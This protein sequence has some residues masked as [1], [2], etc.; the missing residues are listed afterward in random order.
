[1]PRPGTPRIA[2]SL[3]KHQFLNSIYPRPPWQSVTVTTT[4]SSCELAESVKDAL[5]QIY[6]DLGDNNM[7]KIK[8]LLIHSNLSS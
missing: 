7:T 3:E 4:G 1:M 5:Y 2:G 6:T 8:K